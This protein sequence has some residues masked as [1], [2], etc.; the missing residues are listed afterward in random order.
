MLKKVLLIAAGVFALLLVIGLVVGED[1]KGTA[2]EPA[3]VEVTQQDEPPAEPQAV[4]PPAEPEQSD[5]QIAQ[6][7]EQYMKDSLG[8]SGDWHEYSARCLADTTLDADRCWQPY[9]N[10]FTYNS[11]VLRV[12]LQVDRS[13]P[14]NQAL[15]ENAAK[16]IARFISTSTDPWASEIDWVEVTDGTGTHIDQESIS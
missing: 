9:V 15:G 10:G 16:H 4:E 13:D 12:A 3:E 6:A 2:T 8:F 1:T 11:G 5:Q 7:A 14:F